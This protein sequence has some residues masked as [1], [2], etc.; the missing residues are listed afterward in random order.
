MARPS[1][2]STSTALAFIATSVVPA[3]APKPAI[4]GASNQ[5]EGDSTTSGSVGSI[6][7]PKTRSTG[8]EP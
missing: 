6:A 7:R 4:A 8:T 1:R 3:I 2:R 5:S